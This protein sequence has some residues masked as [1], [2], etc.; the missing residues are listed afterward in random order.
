MYYGTKTSQNQDFLCFA[1][2]K[3]VLAVLEAVEGQN[4]GLFWRDS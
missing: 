1:A 4:Y 3:L 2:P